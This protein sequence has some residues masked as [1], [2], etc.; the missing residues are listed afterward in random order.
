MSATARQPGMYV[1]EWQLG[2]GH[3]WFGADRIT[4]TERDVGGGVWKYF[5]SSARKTPRLMSVDAFCVLMVGATRR[6]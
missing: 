4:V 5:V 6:G 2:P 3:Y 1:G